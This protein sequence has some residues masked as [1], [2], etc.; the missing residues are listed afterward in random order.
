MNSNN[1]HLARQQAKRK[2]CRCV[3]NIDGR[4]VAEKCEGAVVAFDVKI[5][6]PDEAK[7]F[8]E[9][10]RSLMKEDFP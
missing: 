5:C 4:C 8:Y 9:L 6:G 10:I 3:A 2:T 7:E 1:A